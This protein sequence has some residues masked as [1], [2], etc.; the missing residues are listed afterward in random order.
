M[1]DTAP[2]L[3]WIAGLDRKRTWFN[4]GWLE[5]TGES[6]ENSL[7][8]AWTKFVHPDDLDLYLKTYEEHYQTK[9]PFQLDYRLK[10]QDGSYRWHMNRGLPLFDDQGRVSVWVG[11]MTDIHAQKEIEASQARLVQTIE[12]SSDF[13]GMSDLHQ[14]VIFLNQAGRELIGISGTVFPKV[15]DFFFEEDREKVAQEIFPSTIRDGSWTGEMRFKH[16][17]TGEAIWM[18]YNSF[19]TRDEKSGE[20]TGFATVSRDLTEYKEKEYTLQRALQSR[21]E[22]I[23]IASHELKTP[24]TSLKLQSQMFLRSMEKNDPKATSPERLRAMASQTNEHTVRLNRLIEDMLD[25]SRIRSGQL[26]LEK[27]EYDLAELAQ[28]TVDH[29]ME[30]MPN[31]RVDLPRLHFDGSIRGSWDKHRLEQVLEN[32]LTNAYRYGLG[33]PVDIEIE[34]LDTKALIRIIDH[35]LGIDQ[36][37]LDRIFNRFERAVKASE[38]SGMGLGL[39]ISKNIVEAHGGKIWAESVKGHGSVFNLELPLQ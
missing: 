3:V 22:F 30:H 9:T 37:D 23:S 16:F 19:V 34:K 32:L 25:V 6:M 17:Q 38:I 27:A 33:K 1:A 24:L 29:L 2:V 36:P 14:N 18:H 5:F 8:E 12:S 7:G 11:T 13:I 15:T 39:F 35:G 28:E 20:I 21:D 31:A 26:R 4:K 10:Y